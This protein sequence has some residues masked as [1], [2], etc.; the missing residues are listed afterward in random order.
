MIANDHVLSSVEQQSSNK[1]MPV[2]KLSV[3]DPT[4]LSNG[5][6]TETHSDKG[7]KA[8]TSHENDDTP[9]DIACN[10]FENIPNDPDETGQENKTV[11]NDNDEAKATEKE[12]CA[13][14]DN[15]GVSDSNKVQAIEKSL[16][17]QKSDSAK[18]NVSDAKTNT[19][20]TKT[21]SKPEQRFIFI[22]LRH[23]L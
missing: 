5:T 14:S 1:A 12:V 3:K 17:S 11:N 15:D 4:I 20:N 23:F 10:V 21:S 7:G 22:P 16:V 9:T 18:S 2:L 19:L 13:T 6:P 8:D